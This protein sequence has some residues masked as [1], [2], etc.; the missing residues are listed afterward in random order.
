[1]NRL[2][3]ALVSA[4]A[5]AA[6]ACGATTRGTTFGT[7]VPTMTSATVT[8]VTRDDGKDDDTA[9]TVQ[10]L[11]NTNEL[12]AEATS[13]G[14]EFDDNTVARPMALAMTGP[15]HLNDID[16]ARLRIRM[17]PD[18]DDDW[19]FDVNLTLTF[20]DGTRRTFS[21]DGIKLDEDAPERSLPLSTARR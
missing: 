5:V 4:L 21:W 15:F 11:R 12:G 14:R 16:D 20:S 7:A 9:V 8:F 10:L 3:L 6:S 1:M 18:D 19:T 2:A 17:T 13:V